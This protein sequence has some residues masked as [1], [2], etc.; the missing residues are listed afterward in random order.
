M[1]DFLIQQRYHYL[2]QLGEYYDLRDKGRLLQ[3]AQRPEDP[4]KSYDALLTRLFPEYSFGEKSEIPPSNIYV[5]LPEDKLVAFTDLSS[6][7]KEVFFLLSFFIR[8]SVSNAV[9]AIDEPE[10]HLHP[11]LTRKLIRV[12]LEVQPGNQIWL[13]THNAEIIDEAG[14]DKTIYISRGDNT[15]S[16][17]ILGTDE[18]AAA[19]HL[20][21][22]FGVSGYIGIAKS[23]VFLEGEMASTDRKA[24]GWLFSEHMGAVKL[25]PTGG[26]DN[27]GRINAAVLSILDATIGYCRFYLIRDRDY[28]TPSMIS[29]YKKHTSGRLYV[30]KRNQIENYLL[31]ETVIATVLREVFQVEKTPEQVRQDLVET[32]RIISGEVLREMVSFRMNLL[33]RP[34]DF[35]LG[36]LLEK[37][38][39]LDH[40]NE[41][42]PEQVEAFATH[43][44]KSVQAVEEQIKELSTDEAV[45]R[46]LDECKTDIK[47]SLTSDTWQDFF[48]GKRLLEEL[49]KR[50]GLKNHIAFQNTLIKEL[51]T[52]P[53][54]IPA[55]LSELMESIAAGENL[56]H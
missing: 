54:R 17:V 10:L 29:T 37:Q 15:S 25:I 33:F 52:N 41:W 38:A 28:L 26:V 34:Q 42:L 40:E 11:E 31:D 2:N 51:A 18:T 32:C 16:E 55:E 1:Y 39:V 27:L 19:L 53:V 48:P 35:G 5:R 44:R 12:M 46:L 45:R 49:S 8:H 3:E 6:G 13:A 23:M 21:S 4:L 22:L 14:R 47:T 36:K 43:L 50:Y 24:F 56:L 30:L 20:R 9:I 7:E